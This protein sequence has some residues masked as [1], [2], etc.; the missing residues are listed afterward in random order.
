MNGFFCFCYDKQASIAICFGELLN[1]LKP[2]VQVISTKMPH[3]NAIFQNEE[4]TPYKYQQ[5]AIDAILEH[6][7]DDDQDKCVL[8]MCLRSGKSFIA[9][10]IIGKLNGKFHPNPLYMCAQVHCIFLYV[11]TY[12]K[13]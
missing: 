8:S 10:Q 12:K 5:D 2:L 11:C 7:Y 1:D 4:K 9:K 3:Q 6:I 13:M